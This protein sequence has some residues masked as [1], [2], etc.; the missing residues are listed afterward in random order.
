MPKT[1]LAI[2]GSHRKNSFTEKMLDLCLEG[3]G[4]DID[5]YKFYPHEMKIKPCT[6][7]W[8]CWTKTKGKCVFKDGYE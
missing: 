6:G 2:S 5:V 7:C 3:M 8:S 1:V 4:K